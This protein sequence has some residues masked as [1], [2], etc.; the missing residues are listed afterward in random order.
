MF[1]VQQRARISSDKTAFT[2]WRHSDMGVRAS[3]SDDLDP[4]NFSSPDHYATLNKGSY[5]RRMT[6]KAEGRLMEISL[7]TFAPNFDSL[8]IMCAHFRSP[9]VSFLPIFFQ[10]YIVNGRSFVIRFAPA[11]VRNRFRSRR[12]AYNR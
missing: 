3:S 5:L 12:S 6:K 9:N 7:H 8:S 11:C 2:G 4:D 10:Y 1:F